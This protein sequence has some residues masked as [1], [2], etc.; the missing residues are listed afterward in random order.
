MEAFETVAELL[1]AVGP[2]EIFLLSYG[3]VLLKQGLDVLQES[4]PPISLLNSVHVSPL[5]EK[6]NQQREK[7]H[8]LCSRPYQGLSPTWGANLPSRIVFLEAGIRNP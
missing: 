1:A 4:E 3:V 6:V 8:A 2:W 7:C 5:Q